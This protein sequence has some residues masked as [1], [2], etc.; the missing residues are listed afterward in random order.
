MMILAK[1]NYQNHAPPFYHSCHAQSLYQHQIHQDFACRS[2]SQHQAPL[3][4]F[5][6]HK[7]KRN[8]KKTYCCQSKAG[9]SIKA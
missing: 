1:D 5:N 6:H 9:V 8:T 2:T 7:K 4:I 3:V